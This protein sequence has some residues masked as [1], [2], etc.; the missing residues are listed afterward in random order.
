MYEGWEESRI[1]S[2]VSNSVNYEIKTSGFK[3]KRPNLSWM[4]IAMKVGRAH[5]TEFA[6]YRRE[7]GDTSHITSLP[8]L[9]QTDFPKQWRLMLKLIG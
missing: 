1:N 2:K 4:N 6:I 9:N 5:G 8:L 7:S 3:A